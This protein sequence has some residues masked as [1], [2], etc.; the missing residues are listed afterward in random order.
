M[1]FDWTIRLWENQEEGKS[2]DYKTSSD[3]AL[4]AAAEGLAYFAFLQD[5]AIITLT[6]HLQVQMDGSAQLPHQQ[7]S[8]VRSCTTSKKMRRY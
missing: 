1:T 5:H 7:F 3:S 2:H 8:V 6:S 4:M